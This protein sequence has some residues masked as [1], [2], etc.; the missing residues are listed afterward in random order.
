VLLGHLGQDFVDLRLVVVDSFEGIEKRAVKSPFSTCPFLSGRKSVCIFP[1]TQFWSPGAIAENEAKARP[2]RKWK[3]RDG[4]RAKK[5]LVFSTSPSVTGGAFFL[6]TF[7]AIV[8]VVL[9]SSELVRGVPVAPLPAGP[10]SS[11][12]L[13]LAGRDHNRIVILSFPPLPPSP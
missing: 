11:W 6:S 1:N 4:R 3:N 5:E 10:P 9:L 12:S 8:P 13:P 2:P 7:G